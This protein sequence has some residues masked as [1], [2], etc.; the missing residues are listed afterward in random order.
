MSRVPASVWGW[1]ATMPIGRP[2]TVARAVTR[3]AAQPARSSSSSSSSTRARATRAHVVAAG[4]AVGDELR[5]PRAWPGRADRRSA[6]RGGSSSAWAGRQATAAPPPGRG[7]RRRR[8]RPG[9]PRR[10][11]G[12]GRPAPPS[13]AG[14]DQHPGE[15]GDHA[16]PGHE[17][18]GVRGHDHDVGQAQQQRRAR[19]RRPGH[20]HARS[21]RRPSSAPA[22]GPPSPADQRA[23]ALADV[24]A[25]RGQ[26]DHEGHALLAARPAA[27]SAMVSPSSWDS[28]PRLWSAST[29]T[30]SVTGR[31]P[32]WL[33]RGRRPRPGR[34]SAGRARGS[35]A[36]P[37]STAAGRYPPP[38]VGPRP[39]SVARRR[40]P[41]RGSGS[42]VPWTPGCEVD[43][44]SMTSR[45]T[46]RRARAGADSDPRL[47]RA[48]PDRATVDA[49]HHDPAPVAAHPAGGGAGR[50][51]RGA[52]ALEGQ[53]GQQ[54]HAVDLG[55]GHQGRCPAAAACS[56]R[57]VAK[58]G[59]L[60]ARA[61]AGSGRCR[62]G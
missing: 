26:V 31:P 40:G 60:A 2:S 44:T 42:M 46:A 21:A 55:L 39:G 22:P 49:V 36:A 8:Q 38:V 32:M 52:E 43:S 37:T 25:A 59:A 56:S 30:T 19:H 15:L 6:S 41:G 34:G 35:S 45:I 13:S 27:A 18:V 5:R 4:R 29:S 3:L 50:Q 57:H 10:W 28:A 62:P 12:R 48:R 14:V 7:R 61:G 47:R 20:D 33:H 9:W 51:Q 24:G 16:G 17:G 53:R 23:D 54:P 58:A 11:S 1:L